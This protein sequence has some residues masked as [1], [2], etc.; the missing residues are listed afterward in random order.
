MPV[1]GQCQKHAKEDDKDARKP[2]TRQPAV[3]ERDVRCVLLSSCALPAMSMR[4]RV[5]ACVCVCVCVSV[6]IY[7]Y[8]LKCMYVWFLLVA[9]GV[10]GSQDYPSM[11]AGRKPSHTYNALRLHQIFG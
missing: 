3:L 9:V 1:A 7:V 4:S 10:L 8:V 2:S 11:F 5:F 6:S